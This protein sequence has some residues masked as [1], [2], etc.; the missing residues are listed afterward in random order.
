MYDD[1]LPLLSVIYLLIC[2]SRHCYTC[3]NN[4]WCPSSSATTTTASAANGMVILCL[5]VLVYATFSLPNFCQNPCDCTHSCM[6]LTVIYLSRYVVRVLPC[7]LLQCATHICTAH[8]PSHDS[9]DTLPV[10]HSLTALNLYGPD[11]QSSTTRTLVFNMMAPPVVQSFHAMDQLIPMTVTTSTHSTP[12]THVARYATW[13]H[14]LPT[15]VKNTFLACIL[16]RIDKGR[17][18]VCVVYEV[19]PIHISGTHAPLP[20]FHEQV[21]Y[22]RRKGETNSATGKQYYDYGYST[23]DGSGVDTYGK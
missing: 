13:V 11:G 19:A 5:C 22:P 4:R 17:L 14:L 16:S 3:T 1:R 6:D 21:D 8:H 2:Y 7:L 23:V 10:A 20:M 9:H 12:M 15:H 18:G